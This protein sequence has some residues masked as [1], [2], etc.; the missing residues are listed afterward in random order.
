MKKLQI[1][2][3]LSVM[4][5]FSVVL[6]TSCIKKPSASF[7]VS[8]TNPKVGESVSFTNTSTDAKTYE[9]NFGDGYTSSES[10][11]SHVYSS[12]GYK[13]V[14]LTAY[15]K[16]E[17]KSDNSSASINVKAIGDVM[18]WTDESTVYNITVTLRGIDKKITGYYYSAPSYCGA[19]GCATYNDIEVGTYSFTA[20]NLLYSWS[21]TVTVYDGQCSRMLLYSSKAK[22]QQHP[23]NQS[24]ELLKECSAEE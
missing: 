20:E 1:S 22:T 12:A 15:S 10:N 6:L 2:K 23:E 3:S 18:F 9:W 19:S 24:T 14:T 7:S 8:N 4:L 21:G 11:P 16:K 5:L 17:K 13:N